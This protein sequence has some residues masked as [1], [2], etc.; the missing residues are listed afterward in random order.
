MIEQISALTLAVRDMV[1]SIEFYRKLGF[2]L[3]YGA[4]AAGFS[5]LKTGESFVN[6]VASPVYEPKWWG[7]VIFRVDDVDAYYGKR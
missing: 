4:E 6:L 2:E 3:V 1:R 5:S 7:R